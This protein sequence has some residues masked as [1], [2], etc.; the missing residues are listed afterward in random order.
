MTE[1]FHRIRRLPPY[2]FAEVNKA[3]AQARARGEDIIDLGMGNPDTP[4][5][6]HIVQKLVETVADPRAHRYS[7]SRGI[8]G[9]R[10]ALAGY[11]ERRFN[12]KLDPETEVIA[13]LGSKEGL[14][15]L[16]SAI[17]SPGDTILVPN[18]SYP[19]HQFGF[20]IAGASVRSIP[21]TPDDE[22]LEALERAVRHSVPK[23]TA[24]IVNFPSNPT[25]Y[26]ADIDFYRKLVAFA[27]KHEIWIL[28]DLAYAEIYFGDNVPPSILAVPGAKDIA[29]EFTSLS[30]TYSMA[31]WRMGFAAG[32][33]KLIAALTRIK[34]YLDYGAFTPIQVAAVAALSGP[35]DCVAE[36]RDIYRKRRDV[37]IHGLHAAGWDVPSPEGSMFAWA[38]IPQRFRELGSVGF[39]K[40][41]LQKAGVA[42]APGLGFGEH[43][44]GFVRIG[45]VENTQRLRQATR[46]I[47]HF[48]AEH[49]GIAPT[50]QQAPPLPDEQPAHS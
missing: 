39:S 50:T 44:E 12:V 2:V 28:S 30:K 47:R 16:A 22:M 29:V 13:T 48:M 36:I 1:E 23:P 21:A 45:L 26:L 14:A 37:L 5:P 42:V 4:T 8:P 11:Y 25:A 15:N 10:R 34:S 17:T 19:I 27:R 33:P 9:L 7:V 31:G 41:L 38:P 6:P 46:S 18:P 32:N 20:I 3:K 40:L 43:G 49:G 35:Q 24:L